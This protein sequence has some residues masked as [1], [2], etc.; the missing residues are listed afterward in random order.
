[1]SIFPRVCVGGWGVGGGEMAC[2]MYKGNETSNPKPQE[3]DRVPKP[4][5][6]KL[7]TSSVFS[8]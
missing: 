7:G 1:M 5:G 8:K 4:W 3:L 6:K 2:H